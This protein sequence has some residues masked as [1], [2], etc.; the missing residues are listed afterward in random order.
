[1]SNLIAKCQLSLAHS[2]LILIKSPSLSSIFELFSFILSRIDRIPSY[3]KVFA[4]EQ[5]S[6][7]VK[8]ISHDPHPP[9]HRKLIRIFRSI[10]SNCSLYLLNI[11]TNESFPAV[12]SLLTRRKYDSSRLLFQLSGCDSVL[13]KCLCSSFM[14][15]K[16]SSFLCHFSSARIFHVSWT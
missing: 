7:K 4:S 12:A 11:E 10:R 16:V 14:R 1:M 3:R 13:N 6:G 8:H 9:P 15:K 5:L 2:N